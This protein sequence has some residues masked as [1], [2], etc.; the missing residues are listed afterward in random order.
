[1]RYLHREFVD[2]LPPYDQINNKEIY[3]N[4]LKR[5]MEVIRLKWPYLWNTKIVFFMMIKCHVIELSS[6]MSL[7][8]KRH[9]IATGSTIS[10]ASNTHGFT[11]LPQD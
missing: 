9:R 7:S 10:Y 6:L 5:L 11:F 8:P 3:C 2:P 4:I 1:M